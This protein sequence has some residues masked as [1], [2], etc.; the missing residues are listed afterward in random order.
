MII[1]YLLT[2]T[3]VF[4]LPYLIFL[5]QRTK[6]KTINFQN[7]V[8]KEFNKN[9]SIKNIICLVLAYFLLV[10]SN[11]ASLGNWLITLIKKTPKESIIHADNKNLH[12]LIQNK[13]V[14]VEFWAEW[15][16]PCQLMDPFLQQFSENHK[17]ITVIKVHAKHKK[18]T[19]KYNIRGIPQILLFKN[20]IEV[21]RRA[22]AMTLDDIENFANEFI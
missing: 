19:K 3:V 13:I 11:M 17:N 14:L 20:G 12:E 1:N 18:Y 21:N 9:K 2:I 6:E 8:E 16:G 15:C 5:D 22:G 7:E 10:I 4:I